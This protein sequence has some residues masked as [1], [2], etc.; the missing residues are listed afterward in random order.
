MI[1]CK[2]VEIVKMTLLEI[3]F[4]FFLFFE[5]SLKNEGEATFEITENGLSYFNTKI[6]Q[7]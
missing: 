3:Y 5:I 4:F 2:M 6:N 1:R 7:I